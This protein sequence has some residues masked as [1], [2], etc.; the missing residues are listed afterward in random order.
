MAKYEPSIGEIGFGVPGA[1]E[2]LEELWSDY[3]VPTWRSYDELENPA[4]SRTKDAVKILPNAAYDALKFVADVGIDVGQAGIASLPTWMGGEGLDALSTD[5]KFKRDAFLHNALGGLSWYDAESNPYTNPQVMEDY[6]KKA[7]DRAWDHLLKH[8]DEGGFMT[9]EKVEKIFKDV[10]DEVYWAKYARDN[11]EG[12]L[13]DFQ[14]LQW[15]KFKEVAGR[16]HR[17]DIL[18]YME[19]DIDRSLMEDY[20]IGTDKGYLSEFDFWDYGMEGNPLFKYS[21]P[22]A[23]KNLGIAQ[24]IPELFMGTG[25]V[26]TALKAPKY[27]RGMQSGKKATGTREGIM[28]NLERIEG[29]GRYKWAEEFLNRRGR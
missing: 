21:T 11:P 18:G 23:E 9:D 10:E 19:T 1:G 27:I 13:K 24:I 4:W 5:Q 2:G 12:S 17:K 29:P 6:R 26:K 28:E 7:A 16:K 8:E 20:G 22:E 15:E 25:L 14:D 3:V